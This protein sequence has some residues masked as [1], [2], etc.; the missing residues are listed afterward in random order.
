MD[1]AFKIKSI[2]TILIK[3]IYTNYKMPLDSKSSISTYVEV[4]RYI[5]LIKAQGA[6]FLR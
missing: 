3:K 4:T 5:R 1:G 2:F 6:K